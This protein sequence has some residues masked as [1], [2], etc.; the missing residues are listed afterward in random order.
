MSG[1]LLS[2]DVVSTDGCSEDLLA[3]GTAPNPAGTTGS[4]GANAV[5]ISLSDRDLT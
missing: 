1:K 2:P 3:L 5:A 4:E